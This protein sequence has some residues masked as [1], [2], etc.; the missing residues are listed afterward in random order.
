M[1][2]FGDSLKGD[3]RQ[4][5]KAVPLRQVLLCRLWR[6]LGR[7]SRLFP[8][9]RRVRF[10]NAFTLIELLVVLAVITLLVS[11]LLPSLE[12]AQSRARRI[13]CISNLH[14]LGVAL[15]IYVTDNRSYPVA[16]TTNGLGNW[17]R[18]LWPSATDRVLYCPQLMPASDQFLQYFPTN[19]FIYPHYGYN[20]SGAVRIN[21]PPQNPG[22]GGNFVWTGPG[23]GNYMAAAENWV[24]VP[25]QMI[26]LGDGMTF[27]PPPL[28][29]PAL[30]PADPLYTIF[31]YILQPQGYPGAN[32]N[33][34]N[35]ANML[36]CDGH[37][38]YAKQSFWLAP[39]DENKRLWNADNQSHPEFQ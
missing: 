33:H 34:A 39:S 9:R 28:T 12:A 17:Q 16:M 21:P 36:F 35:G 37:V 30:S 6:I 18:T 32:K 24:R 1:P 5:N 14:E 11:L 19:Q 13:R 38:Q 7:R 29:L 22:L 15:Q 8:A 26:A 2:Q 27:L 25:S 3:D 31:P 20:A 4:D 23:V 10:P